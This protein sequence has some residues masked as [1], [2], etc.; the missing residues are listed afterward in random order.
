MSIDGGDNGH[1]SAVLTSLRQF[2]R[3]ALKEYLVPIVIRDSGHPTMSGT[4]TLTVVIGDVN[5][6]QH[7]PAHKDVYAY[8]YVGLYYAHAFSICW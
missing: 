8:V 7:H 2:D 6:N 4:N 5:D 3:E 1:G